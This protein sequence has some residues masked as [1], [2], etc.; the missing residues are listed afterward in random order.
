[1]AN[2]IKLDDAVLLTR[3]LS[4]IHHLSGFGEV[5][6]ASFQTLPMLV[7]IMPA[8]PVHPPV[9]P[10]NSVLATGPLLQAAISYNS[11]ASLREPSDCPETDSGGAADS[12]G[13]EVKPTRRRCRRTKKTS[14]AEQFGDSD[15]THADHLV[16]G[17]KLSGPQHFVI[18]SDICNTDVNFGDGFSAVPDT[19]SAPLAGPWA[20]LVAT[21]RG[22]KGAC[23][24]VT[25][26]LQF[27]LEE[28][29]F[30]LAIG[31]ADRAAGQ[32]VLNHENEDSNDGLSF[33]RTDKVIADTVDEKHQAVDGTFGEA[34]FQ[35]A[36][37]ERGHTR[38]VVAGTDA[39]ILRETSTATCGN[40]DD[41]LPP[42]A[43]S[44]ADTKLGHSQDFTGGGSND[45]KVSSG[46]QSL[47][48]TKVYSSDRDIIHDMRISSGRLMPSSQSE[49]ITMGTDVV[50]D[51]SEANDIS[52][53]DSDTVVTGERIAGTEDRS[54][55][56]NFFD[57]Y[58]EE[59]RITAAVSSSFSVGSRISRSSTNVSS[60][61]S[62][63]SLST[64]FSL[65]SESESTSNSPGTSSSCSTLTCSSN[66]AISGE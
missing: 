5:L 26:T 43:Q 3:T 10:V 30:G 64:G 36:H 62:S 48:D 16:H 58:H 9:P 56:R 28:E 32:E 66:V 65:L 42:G 45:D 49:N 61:P 40:D 51:L 50:G 27:Q 54:S 47:A 57:V 1:M 53:H 35:P 22:G 44:H 11:D 41:K 15:G 60:S 8:A 6:V 21:G 29:D 18:G 19:T 24:L 25:D 34:K 13:V 59:D 46:A 52:E 39:V 4:T 55:H 33:L 20:N 14:N 2:Y 31:E 37:G 38:D 23:Q 63:F 17:G 12:G 7:P